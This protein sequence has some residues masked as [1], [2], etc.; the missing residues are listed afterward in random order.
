MKKTTGWTRLGLSAIADQGLF[1]GANFGLSIVLARWLSPPEYGAFA[2]ALTVVLLLRT[3]HTALVVE[4]F[5]VFGPSSRLAPL[6]EYLGRV[7]VFHLILVVGLAVLGVAI[8]AGVFAFL[9]REVGGAILV[10]TI[11]LPATFSLVFLRYVY[12]GVY[13][14]KGAAA[15]S[16]IYLIALAAGLAALRASDH[17]TVSTAFLVQ[18][19][20]SLAALSGILIWRIPFTMPDRDWVNGLRRTVKAHLPFGS[21]LWGSLIANWVAAEV[22]FLLLPAI[23]GVAA[24]GVLRAHFNLFKPIDQISIALSSMLLPAFSRLQSVKQRSDLLQRLLGPTLMAGMLAAGGILLTGGALMDL[25]YAGQYDPERGLILVVA[26]LSLAVPLGRFYGV[27]VKSTGRAKSLFAADLATAAVAV[28]SG[29][30]LIPA[31][32]F[33]GLAVAICGTHL[34]WLLLFRRASNQ[35]REDESPVGPPRGGVE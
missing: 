18:A 35:A 26:F 28:V 22:W 7:T 23:A 34:I 9:S 21:W 1:T 5:L 29:I 14:P 30:L 31:F 8:G 17:L 32:G 20:A 3:A 33:A 19:L 27:F 13:R 10:A 12:Y 25:L 2:I 11:A 15:V 24:S 16:G 6:P 4:P